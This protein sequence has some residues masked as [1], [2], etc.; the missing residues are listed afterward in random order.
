MKRK[1]HT[2]TFW[3]TVKPFLSEK[4]PSDEEI[5]LIEKDKIIKTDIKTA[6]VLNTFFCTIIINLNIL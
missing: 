2:K 1:S 5:T 3:K 4:T 6:N